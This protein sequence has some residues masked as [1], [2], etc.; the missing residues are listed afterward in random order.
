M[1]GRHLSWGSHPWK[2]DTGLHGAA[3]DVRV[4]LAALNSAGPRVHRILEPWIYRLVL[5]HVFPN[6]FSYGA[7]STLDIVRPT[8]L[9]RIPWCVPVHLL[10]LK[11]TEGLWHW[12]WRESST[13]SPHSANAATKRRPSSH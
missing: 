4:N 5:F 8:V 3:C 13:T 7:D 12:G 6:T 10:P 11:T 1:S 9:H 2:G